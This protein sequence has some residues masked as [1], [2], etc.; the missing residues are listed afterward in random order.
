MNHNV[1]YIVYFV[2]LYF[3]RKYFGGLSPPL[4][5]L[6]ALKPPSP[7]CSAA[8]ACTSSTLY[9]TSKYLANILS[10]I[11]NSNSFSVSNS[12]KF[13][14][15][16]ANTTIDDDEIMASFDVVSLF[17]AIPVDGA[18]EQIRNKLMKDKT[19]QYRTNLSIDDI[20]TLLRFTLSNNYFTYKDKTYKQIHGCAMGSPVSPIIANLCM[21]EIEELAIN[22]S[23]TPPRKWKRFVDDV[24]SIIKKNTV[25]TFHNLLNSIDPHISF[26]IEQEHEGRLAFLDT[27]TTWNNGTI[28]LAVNNCS[29]LVGLR[30]REGFSGRLLPFMIFI[31]LNN[32]R[33]KKQVPTWF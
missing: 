27:L 1:C 23:S 13:A 21:E 19:L 10:P 17:T 29:F 8:T 24:F 31:K 22:K 18:C 14:K 30:L 5:I 16:M 2:I 12:A 4:L 28:F 11:Q 26:T 7:P 25:T 15:E 32:Y 33:S 6:G 9:N 20:I 3:S